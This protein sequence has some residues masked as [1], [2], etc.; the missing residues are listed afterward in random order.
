VREGSVEG[1]SCELEVTVGGTEEGRSSG[2]I[3]GSLVTD[4]TLR[5]C[6]GMQV[7]R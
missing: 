2:L 4:C 5:C 6:S 7:D 3:N 1:V